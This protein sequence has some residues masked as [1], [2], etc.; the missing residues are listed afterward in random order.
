MPAAVRLGLRCGVPPRQTQTDN[1]AS[2]CPQ[3]VAGRLYRT[4]PTESQPAMLRIDDEHIAAGDDSWPASR[5]WKKSLTYS[6]HSGILNELSGQG[7]DAAGTLS[8]KGL[9]HADRGDLSFE[10][11]F[12]F[13]LDKLF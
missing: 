3:R 7:P 11:K 12:K 10:K 8:C 5:I 2:G 4:A 9:F 13:I 1:D 6:L